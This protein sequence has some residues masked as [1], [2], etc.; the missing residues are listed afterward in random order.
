[1]SDINKQYLD[2]LEEG[3]GLCIASVREFG[4]LLNYLQ[5]EDGHKGWVFRGQS[6]SSWDLSP[7]LFRDC[8]NANPAGLA[9]RHLEKFKIYARG[10]VPNTDG[11]GDERYWALGRHYGLKTPLLDWSASPFIALFFAFC[12]V[13]ALDTDRALYALDASYVNRVFCQRIGENLRRD[14]SLR[15]SFEERY[16]LS[17]FNP[18]EKNVILGRVII[19]RYDSDLRMSDNESRLFQDF[20][21][22]SINKFIRLLSPKTGDNPRLLSQRGVFTYQTSIEPIE[23][24][25]K[26]SAVPPKQVLLK[27]VIPK[28]IRRRIL[29]FLNNM[30]INHLS[31]FPDLEGASTYCNEKLLEEVSADV[32]DLNINRIWL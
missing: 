29:T 24:I 20:I 15:E 9:V 22:S 5:S 23:R 25:I 2:V 27:I 17:A 4:D 14:D 8:S 18:E 10:R 1:M 16:D 28:E 6:N 3:N 11:W 32:T 12:D 13:T 7:S 19:D 30:N 31:L 21:S 26:S